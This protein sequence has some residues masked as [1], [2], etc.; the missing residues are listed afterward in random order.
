MTH[1][2]DPVLGKVVVSRKRTSRYV[3]LG[4]MPNGEIRVSAP[5]FTPMYFIKSFVKKSRSELGKVL[6]QYRKKYTENMS[7]GKSH[8]LIVRAGFSENKVL[9]K[10]PN[11]YV[12]V[13]EQED[14]SSEELQTEIREIVAKALRV[15]AKAYLPRRVEYIAEQTGLEFSK[16]RFSHAKGRWGSCNSDKTISLNIA[17]MQLPFELIDYV[18][19]HELAHT[20]HLNHSKDFWSLVESA[21]PHYKSHKKTLKNHSPHI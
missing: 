4:V 11:I 19:I 1:F 17:L 9:Y 15:E 12:Y 14:V 7:I 18:I 2:N 6:D 13:A 10:K 3:K 16:L 21:D 8:Q 5:I 20:E